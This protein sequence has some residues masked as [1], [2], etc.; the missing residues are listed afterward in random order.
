MKTFPIVLFWIVIPILS[1]RECITSEPTVEL[2]IGV[3]CCAPA[4]R[5]ILGKNTVPLMIESLI[6]PGLLTF[7]VT[8]DERINNSAN[9]AWLPAE[10]IYNSLS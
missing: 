10:P 7:P 6:E 5:E 4:T 2:L 9:Q 8:I 3:S 1:G